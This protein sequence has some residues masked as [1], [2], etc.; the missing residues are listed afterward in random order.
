M[1]SSTFRTYD[2][3]DSKNEK[4]IDIVKD[5]TFIGSGDKKLGGMRTELIRAIQ[6]FKI[7]ED[8]GI[9]IFLK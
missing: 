9:I 4:L 1:I 2:D 8:E 3:V 6:R 7:V 5:I